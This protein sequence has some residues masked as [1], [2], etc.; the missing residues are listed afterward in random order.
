[1]LLLV[2]QWF[3][4]RAMPVSYYCFFTTTTRPSLDTLPY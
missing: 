4:H 3:S 2:H 1:L